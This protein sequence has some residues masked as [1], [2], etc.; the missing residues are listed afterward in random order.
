[1]RILLKKISDTTHRLEIIRDDHSREQVHLSSRSFVVHDLLH[2]A[3]ETQAGLKQSFWGLL[4]SG[5]RLAELH[6][7][8]TDPDTHKASMASEAEVTEAVVSVLTGVIQ[9]HADASA[10]IE[11]LRRLFSAQ[12]REAPAW[13]TP[14][15]V[16]RVRDQMR[17]LKGEWRALPY[18]RE[19]QLTF[20]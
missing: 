17:R 10:A 1:M 18:G 9:G 6:E 2:Y 19:M 12:G 3:V 11:G 16:E 14:D 7:K 8:A 5:R 13:F 15:F 20:N 4:A